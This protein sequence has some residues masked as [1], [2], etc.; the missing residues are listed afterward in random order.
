MEDPTS[1]EKK[2]LGQTPL[3][4]PMSQIGDL[5]GPQAEGEFVTIGIEK[6]GFITQRL[7]LPGSH[8]GTLVTS[9][10]VKLKEGD[11]AKQAKVAEEVLNR[12][13]LAQKFTLNREFERAQA[14]IDKILVAAPNFARAYSMR[15]SIYFVQKNL[16][17]SLK[18]YEMALK[19]DPQMDEAVK[20]IA[21]VSSMMGRRTPAATGARP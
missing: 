5:L 12:F 2:S 18:W 13:F 3:E 20:M 8:F 11:N 19:A 9:I 6:N 4:I 1:G 15:A 10:D 14:E 7:A 16:P 21:R 17:E